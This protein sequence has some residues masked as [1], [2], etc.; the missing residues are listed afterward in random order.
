MLQYVWPI[1]PGAAGGC[2]DG[3]N[4]A[5]REDIALPPTA[6]AVAAVL[7]SSG[8]DVLCRYRGCCCRGH[9]PFGTMRRRR[10][11][12]GPRR[13]PSTQEEPQHRLLDVAALRTLAGKF[14]VAA[15]GTPADLTY[16]VDWLGDAPSLLTALLVLLSVLLPLLSSLVVLVTNP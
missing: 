7:N 8:G 14:A 1:C 11:S 15:I 6:G 9:A 4:G 2:P 5:C 10:H 12:R 16:K 13:C 3:A